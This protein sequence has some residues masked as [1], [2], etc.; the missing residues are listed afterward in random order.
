MLVARPA[1]IHLQ[2]QHTYPSAAGQALARQAHRVL[3][4]LDSLH[5]EMVTLG[6]GLRGSVRLLCNTAAMSETLALW[7]ARCLVEHPDIDMRCKSC[8]AMKCSWRCVLP[9]WASSRIMWTRRT[10]RCIRGT[11]PLWGCHPIPAEQ[12]LTAASCPQQADSAAPGACLQ[13]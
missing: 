6:H 3:A 10:F 1:C 8:Q 13:L 7:L 9:M 5:I 2:V 4:E 12:V 11:G